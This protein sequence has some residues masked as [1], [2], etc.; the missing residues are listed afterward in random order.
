MIYLLLKLNKAF[1]MVNCRKSG[2]LDHR[3]WRAGWNW[4]FYYEYP[5]FGKM[6]R[7]RAR[8]RTLFPQI[9][10]SQEFVNMINCTVRNLVKVMFANNDRDKNH[11]F[12]NL[13]WNG[14]KTRFY[15]KYQ[16]LIFRLYDA[17]VKKRICFTH[18]IL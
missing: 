12:S 18:F 15:N 9:Q 17:K 16:I 14:F 3:F 7:L 13:R 5:K 6:L 11:F 8:F 10:I 4:C 1:F 2:R